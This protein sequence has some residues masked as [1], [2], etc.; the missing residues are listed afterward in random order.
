MGFI[1]RGWVLR[2]TQA[3]PVWPDAPRSCA[4]HAGGRCRSSSCRSRARPPSSRTTCRRGRAEASMRRL[5]KAERSDNRGTRTATRRELQTADI[6]CDWVAEIRE[7]R[8]LSPLTKSETEQMETQFSRPIWDISIC[9]IVYWPHKCPGSIK[10]LYQMVL[11]ETA[12]QN[13]DHTPG[14]HSDVHGYKATE[15]E[16]RRSIEAKSKKPDIQTTDRV[17]RRRRRTQ[18]PTKSK[19][20]HNLRLAQIKEHDRDKPIGVIERFERQHHPSIHC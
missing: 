14:R 1:K 6:T 7:K 11:S 12:G 5:Q 9:C 18:N 20:Q 10:D 13:N 17:L 15:E 16:S 19:R 2:T 3:R 8:G 4:S